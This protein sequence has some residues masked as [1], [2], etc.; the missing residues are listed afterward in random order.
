M[1]NGWELTLAEIEKNK[2]IKVLRNIKLAQL[3]KTMIGLNLE[4]DNFEFIDEEYAIDNLI[5]FDEI[6][7][8]MKKT[9]SGNMLLSKL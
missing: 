5:L 1:I 7:A 9:N 3:K 4:D 6:R 2:E 8:Q